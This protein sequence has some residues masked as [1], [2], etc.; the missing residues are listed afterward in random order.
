MLE[1]VRNVLVHVSYQHF[2][3]ARFFQEVRK[4]LFLKACRVLHP[5]RTGPALVIP[6]LKGQLSNGKLSY[7]SLLMEAHHGSPGHWK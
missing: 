3:L 7:L 4:A 5:A 1:M 6:R 2:R